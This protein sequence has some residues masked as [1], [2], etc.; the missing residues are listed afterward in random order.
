MLS[1]SGLS[2][3]FNASASMTVSPILKYDSPRER[4][5]EAVT[6]GC[7]VFTTEICDS[8]ETPSLRTRE[9]KA[10]RIGAGTS[11]HSGILA[12]G[13]AVAQAGSRSSAGSSL[14]IRTIR[15]TTARGALRL[16]IG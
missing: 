6:I 12:G 8:R 7:V 14:F 15:W 16:E 13:P 1:G 5:E 11:V 2:A 10:F 9:Q 3:A 4:S